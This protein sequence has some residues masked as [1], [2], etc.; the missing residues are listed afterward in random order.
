M[1]KEQDRPLFGNKPSGG[2]NLL[3][4]IFLIA[5]ILLTL[6]RWQTKPGHLGQTI[7]SGGWWSEPALF[8]AVTL[9]L[10]IVSSA[11]AYFVSPY[12]KLNLNRSLKDYLRVLLITICIIGTVMMMKVFG[13]AL[14]ILIFVTLISFI[15][16]FR[17][18]K[19]LLLSL[20]VTLSM[21]LIFR[22]G[23]EI[24]FPRPLLFKWIDLPIWMQ[25]LM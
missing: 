12:E 24:W 19:V 9:I 7:M 16:G 5:V 18:F 6:I 15:A 20:S 22:V 10:T 17:G 21:M 13:F 8:P 4:A 23:F 3:A 14:S 1:L 2:R 11:V 25:G